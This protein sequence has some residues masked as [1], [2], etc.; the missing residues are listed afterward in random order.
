MSSVNLISGLTAVMVRY[1]IRH[2]NDEKTCKNPRTQPQT[3]SSFLLICSLIVKHI[4]SFLDP[5]YLPHVVWLIPL[6]LALCLPVGAVL[7]SVWGPAS[8]PGAD[9][10]QTEKPAVPVAGQQEALQ[11]DGPEQQVTTRVDVLTELIMWRD[12]RKR[13]E[14]TRHV[15]DFLFAP[16]T[17]DQEQLMIVINIQPIRWSASFIFGV[18]R[19]W[20]D[21]STDGSCLWE[22]FNETQERQ[23]CS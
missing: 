2:T 1:V 7:Q 23:K 4:L 5:E 19:H 9:G 10:H 12:H 15:Q 8:R 17:H 6:R 22:W 11:P 14:T 3:E 13:I 21:T 18:C 16:C 20:S